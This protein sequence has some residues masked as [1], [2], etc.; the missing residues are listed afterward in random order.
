MRACLS[1]LIEGISKRQDCPRRRLY[2]EVF[3][4]GFNSRRVHQ[5]VKGTPCASLLL[6]DDSDLELNSLGASHRIGFRKLPERQY[7]YTNL[8]ILAIYRPRWQTPVG[9]LRRASCTEVH[10]QM[11]STNAFKKAPFGVLF[12]FMD[13]TLELNTLGTLCRIRVH[14]PSLKIDKLACQAKSV[15]IFAFGETSVESTTV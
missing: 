13:S 1:A 14:I 2:Q 15:G 3:G 11:I 9:H 8:E 12:A 6:F 10:E 4:H 7:E 5:K